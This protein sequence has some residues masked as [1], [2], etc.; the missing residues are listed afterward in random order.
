VGEQMSL[1]A[2]ERISMISYGVVELASVGAASLT[3]D[4]LSLTTIQSLNVS[5]DATRLTCMLS[6]L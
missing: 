3:S 2:G 6:A 5:G 4:E 1:T